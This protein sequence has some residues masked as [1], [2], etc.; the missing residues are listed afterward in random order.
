MTSG[1]ACR[2]L[3][4]TRMTLARYSKT[5]K[6]GK[7]MLRRHKITEGKYV[8][9]DEDV[10]GLIGGPKAKNEWR[11]IYARVTKKE[12]M[13]ALDAQVKRALSWCISNGI[14]I[15]RIYKEE[16]DGW[17]FSRQ[18]RRAFHEMM[19]DVMDK[20]I[21]TIIIEAPDRISPIGNEILPAMFLYMG[22]RVVFLLNERI[23]PHHKEDTM[24]ETMKM[25]KEI[26][27]LYENSI[28]KSPPTAEELM[29]RLSVS[30]PIVNHGHVEVEA[31]RPNGLA[32]PGSVGGVGEVVSESGGVTPPSAETDPMLD[33]DGTDIIEK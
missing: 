6:D 4:V 33:A 7:P 13:A 16:A 17:D 19:R 31:G 10:Y 5:M 29:Q 32:Q 22:V 30:S 1:E 2:L 25:V 23:D 21:K 11:V 8:Y 12:G 9:E 3:H 20:N 28:P 27:R 24:L 14:S 15:T 18:N 26:K